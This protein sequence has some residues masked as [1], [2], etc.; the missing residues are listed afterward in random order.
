MTRRSI[1]LGPVL[2]AL[3]LCT[4]CGS[5]AQ[6]RKMATAGAAYGR[7]ADALLSVTQ[8]S[9]VDA[10]SA[11]LLSE[12]RGLSKDE[13]RALLGK[14]DGV[15]QVNA[16]LERLRR[17]ARLLARYFES[18]GRLADNDADASA[19]DATAAAASALNDLGNALSGSSLLDA[20]E[21][22]LLSKTA[23]LS[24]QAIRR[25]ALDREL[26][27]R[28]SLI[29]REIAVQQ[30]MLDAVR[31]KLRADLASLT[32]LGRERDVTKPFVDDAVSDPRGWVA[33]R[34]SYLLTAPDTDALKDASSAA[35]KLR[36]AWKAFVAGGFDE[37]AR[38]ALMTD[39]EQ[40][41]AYAE[42]V[43]RVTDK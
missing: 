20:S 10:D 38:A 32:T 6:A 43:T 9:A 26:S 16:D 2:T 1:A 31:R 23:S 21:R 7:A 27:A 17:H 30:T 19:A 3:A 13:R 28:A 15:T 22:E 8:T 42:A 39:V 29:D 18:L 37:T 36:A 33:L 12:A 4:A 41:V 35:S 11:R 34:R 14:H 25:A 5:A 40:I 24:V